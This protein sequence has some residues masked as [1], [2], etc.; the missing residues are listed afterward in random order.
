MTTTRSL[1]DPPFTLRL[2]LF[3]FLWCCW[4][5]AA[6][7]V[8]GKITRTCV[9][10]LTATR[11]PKYIT[12]VKVCKK[13][14]HIGISSASRP[15]KTTASKNSKTWPRYNNKNSLPLT[16]RGE[17]W[18]KCV[19]SPTL[20]RHLPRG[21]TGGIALT[22]MVV[23]VVMT[24]RM[25]TRLE[26]FWNTPVKHLPQLRDGPWRMMLPRVK[27]RCQLQTNNKT[28]NNN[29]NKKW[30]MTTGTTP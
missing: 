12:N 5:A 26:I 17:K 28:N 2:K 22:S 27:S 24:T 18:R 25:T 1:Y 13:L 23:W 4:M 16:K 15:K 7:I 8:I 20:I 6:N 29:N 9:L 21:E 3:F 30:K 10:L 11:L 19:A 14:Y